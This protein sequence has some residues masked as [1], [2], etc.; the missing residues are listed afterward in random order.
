MAEEELCPESARLY[1]ILSNLTHMDFEAQ[2]HFVSAK[3]E[4]LGI[5]FQSTEF[6]LYGVLTYHLVVGIYGYCC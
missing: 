2:K 6:K 4:Y 3:G 5:T 1:G